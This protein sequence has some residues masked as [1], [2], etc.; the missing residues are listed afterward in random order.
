M[1]YFMLGNHLS[2]RK[3]NKLGVMIIVSKS[4][5]SMPLK[6][7][8]GIGASGEAATNWIFNALTFFEVRPTTPFYVCRTYSI[9]SYNL[10]CF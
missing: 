9:D 3:N 4:T 6:L 1:R 10:F 5:V 2:E 8:F 7:A